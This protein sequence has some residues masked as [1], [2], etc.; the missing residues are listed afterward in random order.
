MNDKK[1]SRL[2]T[3]LPVLAAVL[4]LG[5]F[6]AGA[7]GNVRAALTYY[8]DNYDMDIEVPD[9][10]VTL[11]ENGKDVAWRDYLSGTSETSGSRPLLSW[12][13]SDFRPGQ[14]YDERLT[15]RNSGDVDSYVKVEV[16]KYWTDGSGKKIMDLTPGQIS[17]DLGH[18]FGWWFDEEASTSERSVYYYT[19]MLEPGERT[20]DLSSEIMMAADVLEKC[21]ET[22]VKKDGNGQTITVEYAYDGVRMCLEA[23]V[24]AVQ[25]HNAEDSVKSAWGKTVDV[26]SDGTLSFLD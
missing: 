20:H 11:E 8:S 9:I 5:L 18:D 16:R 13:G 6:T 24:Y 23:D 17:L 21:T 2:R 22:V 14:Y 19:E 1:N 7:A 4:A 3:L 15:V 12:A 26:A 10:G 25:A